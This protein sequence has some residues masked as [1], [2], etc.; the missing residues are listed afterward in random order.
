MGVL[1]RMPDRTRG[2][3]S[4]APDFGLFPIFQSFPEVDARGSTIVLAHGSETELRI[5]NADFGLRAIVRWFE[6]DR[7]VTSADVRA[8]RESYIES[9]SGWAEADWSHYDD[10][11]LSPERPVADLFPAL[12]QVAVGRDG[13][14]WVRQYDR[15]REDRGW[16]AFGPDG[17]FVCHMAGLPAPAWEFGADYVLLLATT[18]LGVQTMHMHRLDPPASS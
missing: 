13:R 1:A 3:V 5:L 14:I 7:E 4:E 18:E 11:R 2:T 8:W 12:S 17:E 10:A 6:P 9:R 15:P 16:L